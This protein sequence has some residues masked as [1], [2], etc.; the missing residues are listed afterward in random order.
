MGPDLT[1]AAVIL[2]LPVLL[3]AVAL[4]GFVAWTLVAILADAVSR[5][6]D[7]EDGP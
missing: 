5:D 3:Q 7:E 4:L 1:T 6:D 2:G